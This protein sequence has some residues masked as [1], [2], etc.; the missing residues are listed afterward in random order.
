M[1]GHFIVNILKT[2]FWVCSIAHVRTSHTENEQQRNFKCLSLLKTYFW[3]GQWSV[4]NDTSNLNVLLCPHRRQ[5]MAGFCGDWKSQATEKVGKTCNLSLKFWYFAHYKSLG[6][7]LI[8]ILKHWNVT[9]KKESFLVNPTSDICF[10]WPK[11]PFYGHLSF[12]KQQ[13]S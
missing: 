2:N 12:E 13:G 11:V 1:G 7:A 4:E 10:L 3:M 9:F 8:L 5:W 6:G